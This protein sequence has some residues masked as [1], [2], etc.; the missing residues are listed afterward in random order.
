MKKVSKIAPNKGEGPVRVTGEI[1]EDADLSEVAKAV[2]DANTPHKGESAP[3]LALV[4]FAELD[5]DSAEKALAALGDLV[6]V[7]GEGSATDAEKGEISVKLA[8]DDDKVTV[9][10]ILE[11]LKGAGV[12]A[13][14]KK[15]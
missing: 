10:D 12:E 7:D 11:C 14:T 13:G 1:A 8:G 3:G 4:L 2:N 15:G 5:E 6:G 9:G